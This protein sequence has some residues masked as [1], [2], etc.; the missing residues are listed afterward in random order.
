MEQGIL[1]AKSEASISRTLFVR[2]VKTIWLSLSICKWGERDGGRERK[3]ETPG[4]VVRTTRR[5]SAAE[6]TSLREA[7]AE[8]E[9]L[10]L[11]IKQLQRNQFGRRAERLDNDQ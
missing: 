1:S 3:V 10:H 8:I 9:R 5:G 2:S 7:N 4:R 6:R 11:I